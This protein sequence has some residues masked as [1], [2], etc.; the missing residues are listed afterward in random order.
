MDNL[1][2]TLTIAF[3]LIAIALSLLGIGWLITGKSKIK[4]GACGRL[5]NK[6]KD[7]SCGDKTLC[8]LCENDKSDCEK[9][10]SDTDPKV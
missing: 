3:V 5:P 8:D 4:P 1:I 10:K 6:N 7:D 9:D 2:L